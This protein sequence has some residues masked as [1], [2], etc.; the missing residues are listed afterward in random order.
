MR[1]SEPV[2]KIMSSSEI[3]FTTKPLTTEQITRG[4]Q[5]LGDTFDVYQQLAEALK[6]G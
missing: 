5:E 2:N 4:M 1:V 3:P 6:K